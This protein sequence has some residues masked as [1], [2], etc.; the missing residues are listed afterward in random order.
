MAQRGWGKTFVAPGS[1]NNVFDNCL[2]VNNR[3]KC[4]S[5][6]LCNNST[7]APNKNWIYFN[8]ISIMEHA[9]KA[10]HQFSTDAMHS[11]GDGDDRLQLRLKHK[12]FN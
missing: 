4:L 8:L 11:G 3:N 5:L 2:T 12:S 6:I 10:C 9:L 7:F 1:F